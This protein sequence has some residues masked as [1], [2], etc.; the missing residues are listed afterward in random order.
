MFTPGD[1]LWGMGDIHFG[2]RILFR[3]SGFISLGY[4]K[5][6]TELQTKNIGRTLWKDLRVRSGKI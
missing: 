2:E 5:I 1:R 6:I 3:K 4:E